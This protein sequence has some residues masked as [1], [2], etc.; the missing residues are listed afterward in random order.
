M[1]FDRRMLLERLLVLAIVILSGSTILSAVA[2]DDYALGVHYY[3]SGYYSQSAF[4]LQKAIQEKSQDPY[5]FFYFGLVEARL[6]HYDEAQQ[7][8]EQVTHLVNSQDDIAACA[9]NNISFITRAQVDSQNKNQAAK[10]VLSVATRQ[11]DNYL[12]SAIAN[13]NV[14]HWDIQ[15]MPLKVYIQDGSRVNGWQPEMKALVVHAMQV[16]QN[17]SLNKIRMIVTSHPEDADITVNWKESFPH[18]KVG[19][20]PFESYGDMI[21]RSDITIATYSTILNGKNDAQNASPASRPLSLPEM[22]K[23]IIHELGHALGI[24]GHSPYPDDIMYYVVNPA[25]KLPA[26][27]PLTF[28]DK[29]TLL[30]LYKITPDIK[31]NAQLTVAASKTYSKLVS[32]GIQCLQTGDNAKAI[33]FYQKA[34]KIKSGDAGLY[35]G[36]AYA[37]QK[38]ENIP[39]A[40]FYY[41][42]SIYLDDNR[43]DSKYNLAGILTNNAINL[44]KNKD[45]HLAKNYFQESIDLYDSVLKSPT[46]PK[47][48]QQN[49]MIAKRNL[50]LI[51]AQ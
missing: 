17:A 42:K 27:N 15:K 50:L 14:V 35:F 25:Q 36:L 16:W 4:Y 23:V 3:K 2:A 21:V 10:S 22:Q 28:R 46:A 5:V 6:K 33:D 51:P 13:G 9:R 7:A 30:L 26:D 29:K 40:I 49:L 37:Y 18:A 43:F 39:Y 47:D 38:M 44:S 31:N 34:L 11:E 24:H 19:E 45:Y 41:R 8:F 1:R 20:N 12:S 32:L 48:T